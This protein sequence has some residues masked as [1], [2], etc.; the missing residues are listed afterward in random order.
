MYGRALAHVDA[1]GC[2][3]ALAG[4]SKRSQVNQRHGAYRPARQRGPDRSHPDASQSSRIPAIPRLRRTDREYHQM[5][6]DFILTVAL[7]SEYRN[8]RFRASIPEDSLPKFRRRCS[9]KRQS[10]WRFLGSAL[11][12]LLFCAGQNLYAE[13]TGTILGTVSDSSGAAVSGANETL[14]NSD[15]GLVRT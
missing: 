2:A 1:G 7:A 3:S 12:A 13:V 8:R 5:K 4:R 10:L 6:V 14:R 15:T 11:A 9:M